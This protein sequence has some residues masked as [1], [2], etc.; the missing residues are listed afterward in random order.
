MTMMDVDAL[1]DIEAQLHTMFEGQQGYWG[2][3]N[4][5]SIFLYA[6]PEFGRIIGMKHHRDVTGKTDFDM[7][8]GTVACAAT[9]RE[10]D[11]EV[12]LGGKSLRVL[13]VHPFADGQWRA[14]LTTKRPFRNR[15][16]KAI[17]ISFHGQDITAPMTIELSSLL[18]RIYSG[19]LKSG[20][21]ARG[22]YCVGDGVGESATLTT[23]ESE[24]LFFLIRGQSANRI[25]EI[26]RISVRTV[27]GHIDALRQKFMCAGKAALIEKAIYLGY[28]R[29]IPKT[30][31]NRQLSLILRD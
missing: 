2:C 29:C 4:S 10:Q 27:E 31:F 24:V 19:D 18:G 7:P 9:F 5:D 23:R 6:N 21:V 17:G 8:C 13:N 1:R 22:S 26:F 20:E 12:V 11:K 28:L 15:S 14:F 16:G 3:K 25:A 30:L